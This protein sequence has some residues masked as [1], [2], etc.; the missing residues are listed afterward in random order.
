MS[1]RINLKN[2]SR[3]KE[4]FSIRNYTFN[5]LDHDLRI[6]GLVNIPVTLYNGSICEVRLNDKGIEEYRKL[7]DFEMMAKISLDNTKW[8]ISK[9]EER[10]EIFEYIKTEAVVIC[11]RLMTCIKNN[12]IE[13]NKSRIKIIFE[14]LHIL[15]SKFVS[16]AYLGMYDKVL[17]E[18]FYSFLNAF[19]N[20]KEINSIFN[21]LFI[22]P[23]YFFMNLDN[24]NLG[25]D[26][27]I[28]IPYSKEYIPIY[29]NCNMNYVNVVQKYELDFFHKIK[30]NYLEIAKQYLAVVPLIFQ[31][32]QENI[33]IGKSIQPIFSILFSQIGYYLDK[34]KLVSGSESL[35]NMRYDEIF[36]LYLS[37]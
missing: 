22:T 30:G 31:L 18:M 12:D 14:D 7:Y 29:G 19:Y 10:S 28:K 34:H 6:E 3:S 11:D 23:N 26:K 13:N 25:E 36:K 21:D 32:G 24:P 1:E 16:F 35:L 20:D 5:I 37:F 15:Y 8:F 33:F 27:K 9:A 17:I 2:Y 4:W